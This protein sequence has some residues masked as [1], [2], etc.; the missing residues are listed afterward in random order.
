[1]DNQ[2]VRD[3]IFTSVGGDPIRLTADERLRHL[4]AAIGRLTVAVAG[5]D[6]RGGAGTS[7]R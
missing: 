4:T 3:M 7:Y 6:G 1:L 2:T 5:S